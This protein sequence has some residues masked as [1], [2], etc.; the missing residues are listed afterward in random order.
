M[1]LAH[2]TR[3]VIFWSFLVAFFYLLRNNKYLWLYTALALIIAGTGLIEI[4]FDKNSII[5]HLVT[6]S[7]EQLDQQYG[8]QEYIRI[9]EYRYFF[10]KYSRNIITCIFGNGVPHSLSSYGYNLFKLQEYQHLF[11]ADVGYALIYIYFGGI[12]LLLYL[13]IFYNVLRQKVSPEY[14]YA[15][16]F[17]VYLMLF[18]MT[19]YGIFTGAI[20]F[21]L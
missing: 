20:F 4:Q 2:V 10:T 6:L 21:L 18:N 12:G 8:G 16:L 15:K 17:I 5:G 3:M 19:S 9:T 13:L 7:E 14:A 11:P 1:T